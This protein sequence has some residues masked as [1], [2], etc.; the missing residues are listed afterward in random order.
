M[1][2]GA[3]VWGETLLVGF[4]ASL[5]GNS[6]AEVT[7]VGTLEGVG[8]MLGF[9]STRVMVVLSLL[10]SVLPES[11]GLEAPEIRV[12]LLWSNVPHKPDNWC[13]LCVVSLLGSTAPRIV[14]VL[15]MHSVCVSLRFYLRIA[16]SKLNCMMKPV[17]QLKQSWTICVANLTGYPNKQKKHLPVE[18]LA[19]SA[20]SFLGH[21]W[22]ER[23]SP[24]VMK[25][26][27]R[28]NVAFHPPT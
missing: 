26:L 23:W 12:S 22:S 16:G 14:G 19:L 8:P 7:R 3:S 21:L 20:V 6:Q 13:V 24:S 4:V 17:G 25:P 1:G 11:A 27:W 9:V 28:K 2:S 5:L 10:G 15:C 18:N